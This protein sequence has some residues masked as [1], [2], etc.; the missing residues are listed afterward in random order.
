MRQRIVAGNW[1]MNTN[2]ESARQL[3]EAVARGVTDDRVVVILCPPFVY[4]PTVAAAIA[5]SRLSLGAQNCHDKPKG[6]Y[7]GE[8]SAEML[9]DVGCK[10]VIIGHSERRHGLGETDTWLNSKLHSAL[11][12]GLHVLFCVG[13]TR[14]ERDAGQVYQVLDRQLTDGLS[15]PGM[16]SATLARI[17]IAYEPVWAIGTGLTAT[18]QDAQDAH[19]HIRRRVGQLFGDAVAANMPI[20]YGGSVDR[21]KAPGLFAQPDTDGGLIG[22]ASLKADDFLS[23][24][25]A[26]AAGK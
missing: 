16:D 2:R 13:E 11:Q 15:G 4:L 24:I 17:I 18:P 7:T 12:A 22:G 14:S 1:K 25:A 6:A 26:A 19:L 8:I 5:G 20:L 21:E 23:I 9:V 10:Y 3:A